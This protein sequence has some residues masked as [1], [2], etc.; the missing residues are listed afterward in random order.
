MLEHSSIAQSTEYKEPSL[1]KKK[2]S[3]TVINKY[4]YNVEAFTYAAM[5]YLNIK[6]TMVGITRLPGKYSAKA[7]VQQCSEKSFNIY[8]CAGLRYSSALLALAH[9]LVHI[10]QAQEGRLDINGGTAKVKQD[11]SIIY[12]GGNS[13]QLE[14]EAQELSRD[15]YAVLRKDYSF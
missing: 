5:D 2:S 3:N 6:N 8:I 9:E 11:G 15:I 13:A 1:V 4:I 10:K 14:Q 7:I 12:K